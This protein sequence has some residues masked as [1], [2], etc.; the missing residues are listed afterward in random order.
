[1]DAPRA[2]PHVFALDHVDDHLRD[3]R[4]EIGDPLEAFDAFV[5]EVNRS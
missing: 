2:V 5:K 1:M 3:V 4:R